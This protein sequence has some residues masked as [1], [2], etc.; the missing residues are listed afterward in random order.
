MGARSRLEADGVIGTV[1]WL[2]RSVESFTERP[3]APPLPRGDWVS[4]EKF[5]RADVSALHLALQYHRTMTGMS[6]PDVPTRLKVLGA[7]T[8]ASG[9]IR[10]ATGGRID[11]DGMV[12]VCRWLDRPVADFLRWTLR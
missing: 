12:A 7:R 11:I 4:D 3:D 6:W 10:Y 2:G 9:L 8:S 1:R 5:L